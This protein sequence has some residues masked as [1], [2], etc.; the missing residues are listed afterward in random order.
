M[1]EVREERWCCRKLQFFFWHIDVTKFLVMCVE[2][3]DLCTLYVHVVVQQ[4][5]FRVIFSVVEEDER[6]RRVKKKKKK[7]EEEEEQK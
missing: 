2:H 1:K 6:R 3:I 5:Q 7:E 4:V